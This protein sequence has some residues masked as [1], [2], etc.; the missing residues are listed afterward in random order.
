[1]DH[2]FRYF[3]SNKPKILIQTFIFIVDW[4]RW[5]EIW[6]DNPLVFVDSDA[7]ERN[8]TEMYKT[9]VK[10]VRTFADIVG[11]QKVAIEVRS[12]IEDFKPH[13]P[14][15]QSLRNPGMRQRHWD[16]LKD[17]TGKNKF[18]V[19]CYYFYIII[20]PNRY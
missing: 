1:M 15:I 11:V 10:S 8:V 17:E 9:I 7:I 6:M 18:T 14:L 5:H 12:E 2:R 19:E 20:I 13:I 3:T 4:L 16:Q